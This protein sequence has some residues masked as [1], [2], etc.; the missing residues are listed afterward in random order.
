MASS[1][2]VADVVSAMLVSLRAQTTPQ[3]GAATYRRGPLRSLRHGRQ[4]VVIIST[5]G[6][7]EG[8]TSAAA[9]NIWWHS[10]RL[11]IALMIP[12]DPADPDQCES[13]RYEI[14]DEF[15]D[16]L[17]ANRT[18]EG[19]AVVGKVAKVDFVIGTLFDDSTQVYRAAIVDIDYRRLQR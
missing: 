9:G 5:V 16:W 6:M 17:Q 19:C 2:R 10:W 18:L 3:L 7:P 8:E 14:L 12:D 1:V 11:Q 13:D 15:M 4:P